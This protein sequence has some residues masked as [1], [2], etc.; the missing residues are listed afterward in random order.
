MNS[1]DRVILDGCIARFKQENELEL[2]DSELFE[3]F[4]L[5]QINKLYDISY[6]SIVNSIVDGGN[7]GGIDSIIILVNNIA[8]D[9]FDDI[10]DIRFNKSTNVKFIITQ[11]KKESSFKETA[12]DRLI[13][14]I[15]ALLNLTK[16]QDELLTRFNPEIV[17]RTQI[18]KDVWTKTATNGGRITVNILY[19]CAASEIQI[20]SSFISK[21]E[22]LLEVTKSNFSINDV[23]FQNYSCKELIQLYQTT[24]NNRLVLEF[25]DTPLSTSFG[26]D[27]GYVGVV[28]LG[29]YKSFLTSETGSIRDDLFE[30]NIRHFQG[31]VDVNKGIKTT[32]AEGLDK[33]FWWFN[34]GITIIAENPNQLGKKLTLENVQIVNGLQTSYSIF[35]SHSGDL[36]DDRAVLVKVIINTDKE[37]IDNIIAS[38]NYQNVVA[39]ALLRATKT[40]QRDLELYFLNEGYYYD[41]RKN[42]YKNQGK[43]SSKIYSIQYTAQAIRAI[44]F[45]DPHTARSKPTALLR[46]NTIYEEIFNSQRNFKGYLNCCLITSKTNNYIVGIANRQQKGVIA[47]FKLHVAWLAPYFS[48]TTNSIIYDQI[49]NFDLS[50]YDSRI[51]QTILDFMLNAINQYKVEHPEANLINM[52]KSKDFTSY[53]Q[54]QLTT[55]IP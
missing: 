43:P 24:K 23:F 1:N 2:N 51:F 44:I 26:E 18:L 40:V 45:S 10:D 22:Q 55:L 21:K 29:N 13:T 36:N 46:N 41:R 9:S 50:R 31:E 25:K 19:V 17:E 5:L 34:N 11:C 28:K 48:L 42:Y 20:S 37:I 53:L 14:T 4:A 49:V 7:D 52:A 33:D 39:P 8:I 38:T 3:R 32:I 35:N 54:E 12:L 6:D 47:N 16:T 27:I 15:P 30:S